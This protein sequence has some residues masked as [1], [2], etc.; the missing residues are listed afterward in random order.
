MFS[1]IERMEVLAVIQ[2]RDGTTKHRASGSDPM[3]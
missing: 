2:H 1:D 3:M